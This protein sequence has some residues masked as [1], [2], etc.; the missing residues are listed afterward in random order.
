[1][2]TGLLSGKFEK[3]RTEREI[4]MGCVRWTFEKDSE[5]LAEAA[6]NSAME[7]IARFASSLYSENAEMYSKEYMRLVAEFWELC[8]SKMDEK[9]NKK[10]EQLKERTK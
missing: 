4:D 10:I 3:M 2:S 1:M 6:T 7:E 8:F 9:M 5:R